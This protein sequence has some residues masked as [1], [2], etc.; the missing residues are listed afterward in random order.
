MIDGESGR[1][2][3]P[4][5]AQKIAAELPL[6]KNSTEKDDGRLEK[7]SDEEIKIREKRKKGGKKQRLD[8]SFQH[9]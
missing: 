4:E 9:I 1:R 7:K 2:R 3:R 6:K 8:G 5:M